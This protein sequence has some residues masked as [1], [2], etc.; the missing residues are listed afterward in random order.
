M[1]SICPKNNLQTSSGNLWAGSQKKDPARGFVCIGGPN[2]NVG[3]GAVVPKLGRPNGGENKSRGEGGHADDAG[4]WG[5]YWM[6]DRPVDWRQSGEAYQL[7]F[8]VQQ[9][10][11]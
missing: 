4:V 9:F 2:R 8:V 10:S 6:F 11:G 1:E 7:F 5:D 3:I